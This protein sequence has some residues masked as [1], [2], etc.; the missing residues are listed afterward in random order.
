MKAISIGTIEINL[1]YNGTNSHIILKDVLHIPSLSSNL[2]SVCKSASFNFSANFSHNSDCIIK[3]PDNEIIGQARLSNDLYLL[4]FTLHDERSYTSNS[5]DS[6]ISI[7]LWH[8][9]LGHLNYNS[10]YLLAKNHD[11]K[12]I[13]HSTKNT[14][15]GCISC[16]RSKQHHIT[17]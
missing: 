17:I 2:L 4:N 5:N 14:L 12:Q 8:N 15:S 10:L 7:E 11:L 9:R 1:F 3:S 13:S 6:G 16:I